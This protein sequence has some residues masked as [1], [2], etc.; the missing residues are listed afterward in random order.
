MYYL[1]LTHEAYSIDQEVL[2]RTKALLPVH[3]L[4]GASILTLAGMFEMEMVVAVNSV[5][6]PLHNFKIAFDN[7]GQLKDEAIRQELALALADVLARVYSE[8]IKLLP[9]SQVYKTWES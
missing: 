7:A 2:A 1:R 8:K 3:W 5:Q 6:I 4:A 9:P